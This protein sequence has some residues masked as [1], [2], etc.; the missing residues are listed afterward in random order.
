MI[1][2]FAID[3]FKSI[4]A[5]QVDLGSVNVFIG[6][7]GSGKSN[8]LEAF[9]LLAAAAS[10]RVDEESLARRGCR[11]G[12][13]GRPMFAGSRPDAETVVTAEGDSATYSASL[14]NPAPF[15]TSFGWEFRREVLRQNGEVIVNRK[16]TTAKGDPAAGLAALRL[17]ELPV[18]GEA[19]VLLKSLAAF[20]LYTP[21][22]PV[23][24]GWRQDPRSRQPVG[25]S[26]GRL[27]EA[28]FEVMSKTETGNQVDALLRATTDWFGALEADFLAAGP[29]LDILFK[30]RFVTAIDTRPLAFGP[31]EVNEGVLYVLFLAVLCLHPAAPRLFAL[32]NADHGL[33]PALAKR[34]VEVMCGWLLEGKPPRQVLM[35]TQNPLVLDGLPLQDDRVRLFIVDRDNR[36][37]TQVR[38]FALSERH[39]EMA[40]KGWTL[41]RMWVNGL[42]GGVPNV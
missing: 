12:G 6:A 39:R 23:L 8:L 7:N 24:R 1:K 34:L 3:S 35:A 10:G 28:I 2:K 4:E 40:G 9:A 27:G 11:P 13:F 30:D 42:I 19:A 31:N 29:G 22:T 5:A 16:A 17:A 32:D 38:R 41:S 25:L 36:G 37:T 26:G 20:N 33:N 14:S 21:D 18:E 15:P